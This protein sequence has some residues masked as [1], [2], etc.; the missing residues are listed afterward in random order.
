MAQVALNCCTCPFIPLY[1]R[2]S[3]PHIFAAFTCEPGK[4]VDIDT[5]QCKECAAGTFSLGGGVRYE[6]FDAA[7]GL[8]HAFTITNRS[9][10]QRTSSDECDKK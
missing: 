4:Y 8:P 3:Y 2:Q 7:V 9:P 1:S 5:Q 10:L 6:D